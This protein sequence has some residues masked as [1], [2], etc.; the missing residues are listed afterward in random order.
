M[1]NVESNQGIFSSYLCIFGEILRI[2]FL[3]MQ[4]W[5]IPPFD[6][7][8]WWSLRELLDIYSIVPKI[9]PTLRARSDA[10]SDSPV[11][12]AFLAF[13][14]ILRLSSSSL[15]F[16]GYE[17]EKEKVSRYL[18]HC[19]PHQLELYT[20]LVVRKQIDVYVY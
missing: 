6:S 17:K 5:L 9:K 14:S 4:K 19:V 8:W 10:A 12:P 15:A 13:S 3:V 16:H 18:P 1:L 2:Y 11:I 7:W 20:F